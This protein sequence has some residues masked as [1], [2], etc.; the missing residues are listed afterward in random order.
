MAKGEAKAWEPRARGEGKGQKSRRPKR[1]KHREP[2][3][4][5]NA[6]GAK[7]FRPRR[8]TASR[9]AF[10]TPPF[11]V[12]TGHARPPT[13]IGS[14]ARRASIARF[15]RASR[16]PLRMKAEKQQPHPSR[17]DASPCMAPETPAPNAR[18]DEDRASTQGVRPGQDAPSTPAPLAPNVTLSLYRATGIQRPP[19]RVLLQLLHGARQPKADEQVGPRLSA[20][21]A[22]R[23]PKRTSRWSQTGSRR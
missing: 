3:C 4:S 18:R 8:N 2:G 15:E 7:A 17:K 12:P 1:E 23:A 13:R 6:R 21:A 5:Q 19:N 16:P 20:R 22:R 14:A 9:P 10:R 11:A